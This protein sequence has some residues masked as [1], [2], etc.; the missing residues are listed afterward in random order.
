MLDL[1]QSVQHSLRETVGMDEY[2]EAGDDFLSSSLL[3]FLRSSDKANWKVGWTTLNPARLKRIWSDYSKTGVV[4]D[5]RGMNEIAE[6]MFRKVA[7]FEKANAISGH[8]S[9]NVRPEADELAEGWGY[10]PLTDEEWGQ[11]LDGM[12]DQSGRWLVSDYGLPY[13]QR[14]CFKLDDEG[15]SAEDKLL[16]VDQMLNVVHQ[17]GDLAAQF[18]DGEDLELPEG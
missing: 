18:V 6:E 13:L 9:C 7:A 14:L 15:L 4:R 17:R 2:V 1:L 10:P 3:S 8:D 11:Y 12:V 5:E 16:I